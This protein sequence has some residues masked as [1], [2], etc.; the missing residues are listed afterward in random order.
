[1]EVVL[2]SLESVGNAVE[3]TGKME[4]LWKAMVRWDFPFLV[5][6]NIHEMIFDKLSV[7]SQNIVPR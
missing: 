1:M 4:L 3:S 2:V 6:E 5:K 7:N